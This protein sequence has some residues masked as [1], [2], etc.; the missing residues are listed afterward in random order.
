MLELNRLI[1]AL[2]LGALSLSAQAVEWQALPMK[3]PEPPNNPSTP[4]KV[5]LG[6]MLYHEVR[7]SSNGVLSC[8]SCPNGM[9]FGLQFGSV[10]GWA[11]AQ[12]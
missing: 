9:E 12:S 5:E 3:A 8:N 7:I 4:A 10:L 1:G 2:A 11:C 6:K